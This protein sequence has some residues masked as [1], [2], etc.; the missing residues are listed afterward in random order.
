M[1]YVPQYPVQDHITFVVSLVMPSAGSAIGSS[2]FII[3]ITIGLCR[4]ASTSQ[5]KGV[6]ELSS[7]WYAWIDATRN[8][9]Y[10]NTPP[11][12]TNVPKAIPRN[13]LSNMSKS[14]RSFFL[15]V[16][17][18]TIANKSTS[19]MNYLVMLDVLIGQANKLELMY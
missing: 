9:A 5:P 17:K 3:P 4:S 11:T 1:S 13:T 12:N 18:S 8:N 14:F 2:H 7:I 19:P 6:G 15:P 16:S 10:P